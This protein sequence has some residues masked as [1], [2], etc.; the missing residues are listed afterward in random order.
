M[1][2]VVAAALFWKRSTKYGALAAVLSVAVLWLYFFTNNIEDVGGGLMPV[3]LF[4][5]VAAAAMIVVSLVTKPPSQA[6]LEKFFPT[7][8]KIAADSALPAHEKKVW[9]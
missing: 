3:A 7:D 2:P 1:F 6:V 5:G 4:L 9:S 8:G